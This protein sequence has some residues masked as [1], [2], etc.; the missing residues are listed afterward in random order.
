MFMWMKMPLNDMMEREKKKIEDFMK[1]VTEHNFDQQSLLL[2]KELE[3]DGFTH[4]EKI[5]RA[6]G[7][8]ARKT[9]NNLHCYILLYLNRV[10]HGLMNVSK[11]LY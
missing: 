9:V 2:L 10:I 3:H 1:E 11:E 6:C 7:K 5:E 4:V 8:Y